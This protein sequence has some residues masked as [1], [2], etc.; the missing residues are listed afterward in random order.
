MTIPTPFPT[1][2]ATSVGNTFIYANTTTNNLAGPI[3]LVTTFA[4]A[5]LA[6]GQWNKISSLIAA[7]FLTLIVSLMFQVVNL[8]GWGHTLFISAAFIILVAAQNL[9]KPDYAL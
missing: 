8:T 2:N 7:T 5:L 1:L 9:K 4:I 6:L 3:L